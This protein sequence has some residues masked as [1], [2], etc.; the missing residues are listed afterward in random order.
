MSHLASF[1]AGAEEME[2][3]LTAVGQIGA[4]Y[5]RIEGR[6]FTERR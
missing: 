5:T 3:R 1:R 4:G 6:A 2:E